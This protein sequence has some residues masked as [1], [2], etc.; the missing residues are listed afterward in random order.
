S[1]NATDVA[2]S[3]LAEARAKARELVAGLRHG[4][5]MAVVAAGTQPQVLCGLT[6]HAGTLRAAIDAVPATDGPTRVAGAVARARPPRAGHPN[7]KAL[8]LTDG[9]FAEAP[10]LAADPD[11]ETV[12]VGERTGN[13]A[14]TR[15]QVRRSLLD[16]TGYEVLAEVTNPSDEPVA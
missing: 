1:M 10:R 5:E 15:F 13:V 3:R 14:I 2:P 12:A 7:G 6:G 8:V 11:V 4:D 9:C 16:P